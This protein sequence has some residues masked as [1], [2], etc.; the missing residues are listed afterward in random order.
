VTIA[1]GGGKRAREKVREIKKDAATG[2]VTAVGAATVTE[3]G[4]VAVRP[5]GPRHENKPAS[6]GGNHKDHLGSMEGKFIRKT[7]ISPLKRKTY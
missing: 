6:G 7:R 4:T 3:R 1:I 2:F 5:N